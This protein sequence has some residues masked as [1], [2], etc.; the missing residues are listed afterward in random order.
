M[1]PTARRLQNSGLADRN[2]AVREP[3]LGG[4]AAPRSSPPRNR[5]RGDRRGMTSANGWAIER[6]VFSLSRMIRLFVRACAFLLCL[7]FLAGCAQLKKR[8]E[9]KKRVVAQKATDDASRRP[10]L[11]GRISLVNADDGFVLID[12]ASAPAAR[13]GANWRAYSGD[14]ISAELRATD[15]R[16]RPW[17]V[18]DIVSGEPQK[19]DTVMQ[20]AGVEPGTAPKAEPVH[21]EPAAEATPAAEPAPPTKP[22]PFWKRW[23]GRAN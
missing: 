21:P 14:A 18:A 2:P 15:V 11:V 8:S 3:C 16:R 20:P 9:E 12:A 19:G 13:A 5:S 7:S 6:E 17:I 1:E 23:F 22:A 4:G 10:L